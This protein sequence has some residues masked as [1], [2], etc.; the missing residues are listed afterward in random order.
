MDPRKLFADERHAVCAYCGGIPSTADH[1][2]SRVLLDKPYPNNLPVVRACDACNS[3]FSRDE[4]YLACLVECA[5]MGSTDPRLIARQKVSRMLVEK[6]SLRALVE[7]CRSEGEAGTASWDAD[8]SRVGAVV[9]KL[10]RGHAAYECGEPMLEEPDR[11]SF[12]AVSSLSADERQSFET[13]PVETV[14]PEIGSRAFC[15]VVP[16]SEGLVR[17]GW[18]VVQP[19]RYRY[20]V[21]FSGPITVRFVLS[22]YLACQVVW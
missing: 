7:S 4:S 13:P 14:Y 3:G 19:G 12:I 2:P 18:R 15:R 22:E 6:P 21:S 8:A 1:V 20:L 5:L 9:V 10:A 11:V 16:N 17:N